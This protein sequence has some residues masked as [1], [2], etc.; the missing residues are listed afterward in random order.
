M[1]FKAWRAHCEDI[2]ADENERKPVGQWAELGPEP[3]LK[4]AYNRE[5]D[6]SRVVAL[7]IATEMVE[8][9]VQ[10]Q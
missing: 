10:V 6:P 5:E 8:R 9:G 7:C 2:L 3:I 4:M 1:A